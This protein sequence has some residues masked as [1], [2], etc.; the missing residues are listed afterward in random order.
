M[1]CGGQGEDEADEA[2]RKAKEHLLSAMAELA[3]VTSDHAKM[4]VY[5]RTYR[6]EIQDSAALARLAHKLLNY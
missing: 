1:G 6:Q 3:S 4:A 2:L 5:V